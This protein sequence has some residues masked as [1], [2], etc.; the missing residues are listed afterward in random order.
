MVA[1][2]ESVRIWVGEESINNVTE[3][4]EEG[5][6]QLV[7]DDVSPQELSKDNLVLLNPDGQRIDQIGVKAVVRYSP[8][9]TLF[10]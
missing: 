8:S 1:P 4:D 3:S 5:V 7:W 10:L 9:C 2:L 6:P